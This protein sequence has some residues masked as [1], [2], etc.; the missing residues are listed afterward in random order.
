MVYK[1]D[2][3]DG[4]YGR[5]CVFRCN[6]TPTYPTDCWHSILFTLTVNYDY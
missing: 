3:S 2:C 1:R 5:V 4:T 6:Y